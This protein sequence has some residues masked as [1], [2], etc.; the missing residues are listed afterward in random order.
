MK[1]RWRVVL[2]R[3]KGEILSQVEARD[4]QAAKAALAVQF[5]ARPAAVHRHRAKRE[6][7]L[8]TGS[9]IGPPRYT[10]DQAAFPACLLSSVSNATAAGWCVMD[11]DGEIAS[12]P[13]RVAAMN[14]S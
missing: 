1:R 10:H 14:A 2:L 3:N 6:V 12:G 8:I 13:H 5:A 7:T 4:A 9:I 11:P